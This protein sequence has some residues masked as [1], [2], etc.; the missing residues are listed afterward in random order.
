M[1]VCVSVCVC[2]CVCVYIRMINL[3]RKL[4][5]AAVKGLVSQ[6]RSI[7]SASG[8]SRWKA[9][10]ILSINGIRTYNIDSRLSSSMFKQ[11]S[12]L[13]ATFSPGDAL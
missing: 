2:V 4:C 13:C 6:C 11:T 5:L 9:G 3:L 10:I 1:C 12:P 7:V 8:I